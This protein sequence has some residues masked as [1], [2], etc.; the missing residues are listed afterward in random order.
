MRKKSAKEDW[1]E[2]SWNQL[3]ETGKEKRNIL[4]VSKAYE[5]QI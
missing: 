1:F 3:L 2:S 4:K 5:I